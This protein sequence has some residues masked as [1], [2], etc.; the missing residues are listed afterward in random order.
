MFRR[1]G[2][3]HI[4]VII[5]IA[6]M[7]VGGLVYYALRPKP[8]PSGSPPIST[9]VTATIT[10]SPSPT[11][12]V[13]ANKYFSFVIPQ[14]WTSKIDDANA[15]YPHYS[16]SNQSGDYLSIDIIG[17]GDMAPDAIWEYRL[18]GNNPKQIVITKEQPDCDPGGMCS[19]GNDQLQIGLAF[20]SAESPMT[21]DNMYFFINVGNK[22]NENA[23]RAPLREIL[24]GLKL[25][26][27]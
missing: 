16:F 11:P 21:V 13:Y 27:K 17:G 10:S 3:A 26:T 4:V 18:D 14:G 20:P 5:V 15:A 6:L 12:N 8:S 9:T 23:D 24:K 19:K 1:S 22:N 7:A 25:I 2:S